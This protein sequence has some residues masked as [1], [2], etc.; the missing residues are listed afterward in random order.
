VQLAKELEALVDTWCDLVVQKGLERR[1]MQIASILRNLGTMPPADRPF[2]R[3]LWVAALINPLPALGVALEIRPA[4]LQAPSA[5]AAL[6]VVTSGIQGS[7]GH[8]N[9]SKPLF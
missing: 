1:P 5:A 8:V 7:I 2:D 3:A 4:V 9:G 6:A